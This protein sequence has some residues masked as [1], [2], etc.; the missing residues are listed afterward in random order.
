MD[1]TRHVDEFV[2][3]L[4]AA[5]RGVGL[6]GPSHPLVVRSTAA[7]ADAFS[8][9][10]AATPQVTLVCLGDDVVV[11]RVRVRSS[12]AIAGLVRHLREQQVEKLT[13]PRSLDLGQLRVLVSLLADRT[14]Q[15]LEGR[16]TAAGLRGV[17]IGVIQPDPQGADGQVGVLA[18][19]EMYTSA[20]G[21]ARQLWQEA[22]AGDGPNPGAARQIIDALAR[23]VS[24]DRSSMMALTTM[25]AHDA[26]TFTHMINVALLTMAQ[27]R[28]LGLP[29]SLVREFGMAGLMHD[30]GKTRIP[31]EI[32]S[33]PAD[34]TPEER[35]IIQRHV[36]DGA[37]I[38]RQ[39][40]EMPALVPIV[41]FEHHLR[42][43]MSGY[44]EG[45]GARSLNL[46]TLLVSISD[47]YDALRSNRAYRAGL[48]SDRIRAMLDERSGNTF[49]PTLL[50]R[51]ITLMGMYPV[52]TFVRLATGELAVVVEEHA[53]DPFHPRIR[54][55]A[56]R[57]GAPFVGSAVL[58]TSAR[59]DRG[60]LIWQI[61][62]PVDADGVGVSPLAAMT[63]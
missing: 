60:D 54:L 33:K 8:G 57:A 59:T 19:R 37:Q 4:G 24:Q 44:P 30:V 18:A 47:V 32:L 45:I 56:D 52:G 12:P 22:E 53:T 58:D 31:R 10:C 27:A 17:E 3:R 1:D 6:Y 38:L 26:Y 13:L 43:D 41:A 20:I 28:A 16:L 39:T 63:A 11:G 34:L 55:T 35:A 5:I 25:K 46:C 48:P 15:P 2:K 9:V 42:P 36:V 29:G 21:G 61:V 7:L 50:R 62:E 23:A 51:F 14:G 49:E 40:P